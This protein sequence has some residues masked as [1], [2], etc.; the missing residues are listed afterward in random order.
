MFNCSYV[1]YQSQCPTKSEPHKPQGF[2]NLEIERDGGG[3]RERERVIGSVR[4]GLI[5]L[6]RFWFMCLLY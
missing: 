6:V 2:S 4:S 3:G 5:R 1:I